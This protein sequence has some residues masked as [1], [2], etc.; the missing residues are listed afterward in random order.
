MRTPP[1]PKW[2]RQHLILRCPCIYIYIYIYISVSSGERSANPATSCASGRCGLRRAHI[3][4]FTHK[5]SGLGMP[6]PSEEG[7]KAVSSEGFKAV[8][9]DA[10]CRFTVSGRRSDCTTT[11]KSRNQSQET[12]T[13]SR[14]LTAWKLLPIYLV[15]SCRL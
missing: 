6:A 9:S 2:S 8:S 14:N 4:R 3:S 12:G 7:F 10:S 13:S 1:P 15:G 5:H 11:N